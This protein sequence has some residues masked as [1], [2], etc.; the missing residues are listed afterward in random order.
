MEPKKQLV[1]EHRVTSKKF[2]EERQTIFLSGYYSLLE[3]EIEALK[4]KEII[5]TK[6]TKNENI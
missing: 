4:T 2:A 5:N 1:T 3:K 6:N